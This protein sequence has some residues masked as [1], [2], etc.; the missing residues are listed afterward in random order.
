MRCYFHERC[1]GRPKS[2]GLLVHHQPFL[3]KK[4]Q[5]GGTPVVLSE[6]GKVVTDHTEVC[7][8]FN[9]FFV[10]VTKDIG[11]GGAQYDK[12]FSDQPSIKNI[13]DNLPENLPQFP[14]RPV[15]SAEVT[16]IIFKS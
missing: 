10:D 8:I 12:E 9:N 7:T 1:A 4:G 2:S 15:N 6:G 5:G 13:K 16:K 3:S 11:N 14:F